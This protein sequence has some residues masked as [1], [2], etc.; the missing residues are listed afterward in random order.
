MER[1]NRNTLIIMAGG[2]ST[3]MG[4]IGKKVSKSVIP[5]YES[6]LLDQH[7]KYAKKSKSF[8]KIIIST[9]PDL[10]PI[11]NLTIEDVD[12]VVHENSDHDGGSLKALNSILNY[13]DS[14]FSTVTF[15]DIFFLDNPYNFTEEELQNDILLGYDDFFTEIEAFRGG[16]VI[17]KDKLVTEIIEK[18]IERKYEDA[19]RW[20]GISVIRTNL[21]KKYLPVFLEEVDKEVPEG[22]FYQFLLQQ[23]YA[24]KAT[25]MSDFVNNNNPKL[26]AVTNLYL[27]SKILNSTN[28]KLSE[29]LALEANNLR[30]YLLN[31]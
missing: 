24:I 9:S 4:S 19:Y 23:G 13:V 8:A 5:L 15:A 11:L 26:L 30:N 17:V 2:M 16:I 22:D 21:I 3:R 31:N 6:S 20:N 1:S 14:E 18:P 28:K 12:V 7:V 29:S 27:I 25:K 10:Y